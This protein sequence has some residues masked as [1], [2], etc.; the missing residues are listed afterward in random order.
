MLS[1]IWM[2]RGRREKDA[3]GNPRKEEHGS[4]RPGWV[5]VPA[6]ALR[7]GVPAV[8]LARWVFQRE[9]PSLTTANGRRWVSL[10]DLGRLIQHYGG[11]AKLRVPRTYPKWRY[12]KT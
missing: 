7:T 11:S 4:P 1:S 3:T 5:S 12:K 10:I 2:K 6:G 8:V 9:L